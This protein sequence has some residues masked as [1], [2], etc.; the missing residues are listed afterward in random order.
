MF[1]IC[2]N[3]QLLHP[4]Y[5]LQAMLTLVT[6]KDLIRNSDDVEYGSNIYQIWT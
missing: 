1:L 6:K 4:L 5:K 2:D 3:Y